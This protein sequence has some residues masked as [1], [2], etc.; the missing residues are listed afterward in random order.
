MFPEKGQG[1]P[2]FMW[3][4]ENARTGINTTKDLDGGS[5]TVQHRQ[6]CN[7]GWGF[8]REIWRPPKAQRPMITGARLFSLSC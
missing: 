6:E 4:L 1:D 2:S 5:S 7:R 8:L 3:V